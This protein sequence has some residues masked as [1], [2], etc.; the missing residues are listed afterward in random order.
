[1]NGCTVNGADSGSVAVELEQADLLEIEAEVAIRTSGFVFPV[2][3]P[4]TAQMS[5]NT[6]VNTIQF[7]S[8]QFEKKINLI[9]L[10]NQ[11]I[12]FKTKMKK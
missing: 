4:V 6:I 11:S 1:M 7:N 9:K 2:R 8:N 5:A 10:I 3:Q 12:K